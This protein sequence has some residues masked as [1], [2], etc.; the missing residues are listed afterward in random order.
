[1]RIATGLLLALAWAGAMAA[2][3]AAGDRSRDERPGRSGFVAAGRLAPGDV[4]RFSFRLRRGAVLTAALLDGEGGEFHD[5]VL[6]VFG[7][8]DAEPVALDDDGGPGFLPRL[9]LRAGEG[10]V[11][12]LAVSG[13]GDSDF[14]GSGHEERLRYRLVVAARTDSSH[15]VESEGGRRGQND[16][17][18][19]ADLVRLAS[20]TAI[21]SGRMERGDVDIFEVWM[22][23]DSTLTA[24]V[25]DEAAGEYHDAV[26]RLRD[27]DGKLL[28]ENDDGGPGFLP[29]LVF[30][31]SQRKHARRSFPVYVEL[32][33]LDPDP[34][35]PRPHREEFRYELVLSKDR[36]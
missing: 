28:A 24:S 34:S 5:P 35:D 16:S 10:G 3:S 26:L 22:D 36:R 27:R 15:Q 19:G 4:D 13:F 18:R 7:P 12:T 31:P 14:D 32:T 21:V 6:G 33:G 23:R 25:Y 11:F 1:M 9:A 30:S 29:N 2:E 17:L 8:G 20:G